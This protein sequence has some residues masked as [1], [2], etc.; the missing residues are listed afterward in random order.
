MW[1]LK[2]IKAV[3]IDVMILSHINAFVKACI[4]YLIQKHKLENA[5]DTPAF[6]DSIGIP[7]RV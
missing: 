7:D 3:V 5:P 1:M 2:A 6:P 4:F